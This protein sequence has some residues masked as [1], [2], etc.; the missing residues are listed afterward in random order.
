[1]RSSIRLLA[2][3]GA[4]GAG[5][6][7]L[8]L[9]A[10]PG[11]LACPQVHV[12]AARETLAGPGFGSAEALVNLVAAAFVN[13]T[14]EAINYPAAGGDDYANSVSDGIVAVLGQMQVFANLCPD[15][16]LVA[17][18]YSQVGFPRP[19]PPP[20]PLPTQP[21]RDFCWVEKG[22]RNAVHARE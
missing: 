8:P 18:G 14:A 15:T 20:P 22:G 4:A 6:Q 11:T 16:I 9:V 2:V 5:A 12:F 1:M 7:T 19:Q 13:S 17:H 21:P 10:P 3:L